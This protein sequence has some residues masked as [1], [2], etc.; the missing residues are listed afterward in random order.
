M[1]LFMEVCYARDKFDVNCVNSQE[2]EIKLLKVEYI[3][4]CAYKCSTP[5]EKEIK[6][7]LEAY[8]IK[9]SDSHF[10]SPVM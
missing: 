2:V 3:T 9:E 6:K 10:S 5:D 1:Q 8:L 4:S 7:H